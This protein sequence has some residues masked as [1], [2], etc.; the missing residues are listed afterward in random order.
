MVTYILLGVCAVSM[1]ANLALLISTKDDATRAVLADMVFY[2]MLAFYIG[3]A[4]LNDTSIVYEV[5]LLGAL[6]GLLSTVSVSRILSK[7]RR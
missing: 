5:L 6:L 3:W 2:L 4:I 7:G 1:I